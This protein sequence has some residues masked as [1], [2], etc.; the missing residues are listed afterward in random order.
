VILYQSATERHI[1]AQ[2]KRWTT[3]G[4]ARSQTRSEPPIAAL[5]S[6]TSSSLSIGGMYTCQQVHLSECPP[7]KSTPLY[8]WGLPTQRPLSWL[9]RPDACHASQPM[10]KVRPNGRPC[11]RPCQLPARLGLHGL[12]PDDVAQRVVRRARDLSPA[13][14]QRRT[15]DRA[16]ALS[17]SSSIAAVADL[18]AGCRSGSVRLVL[19]A[20]RLAMRQTRQ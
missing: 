10:P 13:E 17:V 18:Q 12:V 3:L 9:L 7:H 15:A 20:A 5:R 6:R 19:K 8:D 11:A 4:R 1:R 16:P 14:L 2:R